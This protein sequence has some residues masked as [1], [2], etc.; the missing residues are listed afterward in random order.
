MFTM[1][2]LA[3]GPENWSQEHLDAR[4]DAEKCPFLGAT[5]KSHVSICPSW[6][7]HHPASKQKGCCSPRS[8]PATLRQPG[9]P[10]RAAE[11]GVTHIWY[12]ACVQG[13]HLP[14]PKGNKPSHG[15]T[16]SRCKTSLY[17]QREPRNASLCLAWPQSLMRDTH[18]KAGLVP[19]AFQAWR[20]FLLSTGT[21]LRGLH[22]W[23]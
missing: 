19:A 14:L 22:S 2:H 8:A 11:R 12:V 10:R 1:H 13:P 4:E 15:R 17:S 18:G 9:A 16:F 3:G 6:S 23:P 5:E 21:G 7:A 20:F